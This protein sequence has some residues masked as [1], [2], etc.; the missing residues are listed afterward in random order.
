MENKKHGKKPLKRVEKGLKS[1]KKAVSVIHFMRGVSRIL[2]WSK[3][4]E[5]WKIS[6]Y[7]RPKFR[8]KFQKNKK[9]FMENFGKSA[10]NTSHNN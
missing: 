10:K 5:K 6:V 3:N 8:K 9:K 7:A 2:Y 4:M 1:D